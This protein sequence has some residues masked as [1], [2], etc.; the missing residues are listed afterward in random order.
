MTENAR[1]AEADGQPPVMVGDRSSPGSSRREAQLVLAAKSSAAERDALI[2]AFLPLTGSVARLYRGSAGVG[3]DELMQEG[4]V[5]LLRALERFDPA[6]GTPFWGYASW[7]VR[8]A[9][10]QVVSELTRPVVL[11]DRAVRQLTRVRNA[12]REHVRAHG[13]EPTSSEVAADTGLSRVQV[14]SLIVADRRAQALD[15]PLPRLEG[16]GGTYGELLA[17]P[18]AED[19]YD[20]VPERIDAEDVPTLLGELDER[21]RTIVS[22]RFGFAGDEQTLREVGAGLGVSIERVRQLEERAL[23]K[24]R[25]A[26]TANRVDRRPRRPTKRRTRRA[27][28]RPEKIASRA[29]A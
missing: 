12:R 11:S 26:A 4:A 28:P 16:G 6:R 7:W 22:A 2:E 24:M 5:G 25:T 8:Q 29:T 10:Q 14:D 9:M 13:K 15:E 27:G 17:D 3:H 1:C 18:L 21:E 23:S 20:R 19:A